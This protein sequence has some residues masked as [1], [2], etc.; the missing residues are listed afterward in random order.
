MNGGTCTNDVD[1]YQCA[2]VAGYEG[3]DCQTGM[4]NSGVFTLYVLR[5][6]MFC[7]IKTSTNLYLKSAYFIY[8]L[9]QMTIS[10]YCQTLFEVFARC[11]DEDSVNICRI[12]ICQTVLNIEI[13]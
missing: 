2:C 6:S 13:Y 8:E 11:Y 12:Y 10:Q 3:D 4:C 9:Y 7:C 1:S 5:G